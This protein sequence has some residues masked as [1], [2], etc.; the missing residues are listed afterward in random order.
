MSF[1]I[2]VRTRDIGIRM[3]LGAGRR[4]IVM[5][6]VRRALV[7][8]G[9]GVA[10][11]LPL[12]ISIFL[13]MQERPGH[14]PSAWLAVALALAQGIGVMLLVALAACLVPARRALRISPVEA[15]RGDG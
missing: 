1:T 5:Q 10:A 9:T 7:Q 3:A 4:R 12:A 8:I 2:A 15:L 13:E 14:A 6:I 11:G